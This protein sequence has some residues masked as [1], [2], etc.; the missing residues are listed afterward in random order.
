MLLLLILLESHSTW[1]GLALLLLGSFP[2]S[3]C[4]FTPL[5]SPPAAL[6]TFPPS[7]AP[8]RP[9]RAA[10]PHGLR[11]RGRRRGGRKSC[12]SAPNQ[13]AADPFSGGNQ[14]LHFGTNKKKGSSE[15][16][17]FSDCSSDMASSKHRWAL[18]WGSK[19]MKKG[20]HFHGAS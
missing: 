20:C 4:F 7:P 19:Y 11:A 14:G 5:N 1:W 16:A 17:G 12:G 6:P 3:L 2:P 8:P 18:P 15:L 9:R 10:P 13:A